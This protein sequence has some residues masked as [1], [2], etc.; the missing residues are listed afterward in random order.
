M[1]TT[2]GK[3]D[4]NGKDDNSEHDGKDSKDDW[5]GR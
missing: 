5:Q 1:A 4:D 2:T 3:D